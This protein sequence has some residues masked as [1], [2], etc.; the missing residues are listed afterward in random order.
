MRAPECPVHERILRSDPSSIWRAR[1][2]QAADQRAQQRPGSELTTTTYTSTTSNLMRCSNL[3]HPTFRRSSKQSH[4][5]R[6]RP[7][8][9]A[10]IVRFG[11]TSESGHCK[12]T[13]IPHLPQVPY[14]GESILIAHNILN[15][16]IC[17]FGCSPRIE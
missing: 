7:N 11:I 15:S 4:C 17:H 10:I 6:F 3:F 16:E 2:I 9:S 14:W 8:V 12:V 5:E 1:A 13:T